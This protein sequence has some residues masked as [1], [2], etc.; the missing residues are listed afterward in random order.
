MI[1]G[2]FQVFNTE[3]PNLKDLEVAQEHAV[4][5]GDLTR[6]I[7]STSMVSRAAGHKSFITYDIT[8]TVVPGN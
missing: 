7:F 3:R 6:N 1:F 4:L 8:V 2:I 5:G